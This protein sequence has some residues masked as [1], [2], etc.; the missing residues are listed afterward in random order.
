MHRQRSITIRD[1]QHTLQ[2][3]NDI[4]C[5]AVIQ[6]RIEPGSQQPEPV[7]QQALAGSR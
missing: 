5:V 3:R 7:P 4:E 1:G 2:Q 6:K